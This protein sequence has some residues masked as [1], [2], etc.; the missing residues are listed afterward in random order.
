MQAESHLL[1]VLPVIAVQDSA[2]FTSTEMLLGEFADGLFFRDYH[3][4][5][6]LPY[7][8]QGAS[9]ILTSLSTVQ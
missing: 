3:Y 5:I 7:G 4:L 2:H 9:T 1:E 8:I 6:K